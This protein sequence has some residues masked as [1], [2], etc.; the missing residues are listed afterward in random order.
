MIPL[1]LV[2]PAD[3]PS[4]AGHPVVVRRRRSLTSA[5]QTVK[6]RCS[7]DKLN[8]SDD[9]G[10]TKLPRSSGASKE[11]TLKPDDVQSCADSPPRL[12]VL[13]ELPGDSLHRSSTFRTSLEKAVEDI[14]VKY[15]TARLPENQMEEIGNS[16]RVC[17]TRPHPFYARNNFQPR[18]RLPHFVNTPTVRTQPVVGELK[19]GSPCSSKLTSN[20]ASSPLSDCR[21]EETL[22]RAVSRT[23][24]AKG[25]SP[26]T[27]QEIPG[28]DNCELA[29]EASPG[30]SDVLTE[31]FRDF[32]D[33]EAHAPA[34][35]QSDASGQSEQ[36]VEDDTCEAEVHVADESLVIADSIP[37]TF[38]AT[39]EDEQP[40]ARRPDTLAPN[41]FCW[42][43]S[44]QEDNSQAEDPKDF[45][46]LVIGRVRESSDNSD[47][48]TETDLV[49]LQK[50]PSHDSNSSAHREHQRAP[51]VSE[52]VSKFGRMASSRKSRDSS[53]SR[54]VAWPYP[55]GKTV[56]FGT[57]HRKMSLDSGD[58]ES[59]MSASDNPE[60]GNIQIA[61]KSRRIESSADNSGRDD[62]C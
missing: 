30:P 17:S 6:T 53:L 11:S 61:S 62:I 45:P 34:Q 22:D 48:L 37:G 56:R 43:T 21:T 47:A 25:Q 10:T 23:E 51:S 46:A 13:S 20:V 49:G 18:Y 59:Q 1:Q 24:C 36:L 31:P 15:G 27:K 5:F 35:Q 7:R 32:H 40:Q 58:C 60:E 55:V 29:Q 8:D 26:V 39:L 41:V 14:N 28:F 4:P 33:G 12:D 38:P 16:D 50:A 52:L 9:S 19:M 44:Q 2:P 42:R 3:Q 57:C 54:E